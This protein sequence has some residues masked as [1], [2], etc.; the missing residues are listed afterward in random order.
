MTQESKY[1]WAAAIAAIVST[2]S[3]DFRELANIAQLDP[4]AGDLSDVDFSGLDLSGQNLGGWDLSKAKFVNARLTETELRSALVDPEEIIEAVDWEEANLDDSVRM[5]AKMAAK[6]KLSR[7]SRRVQ[8]LQ[9][10]V[11]TANCLKNQEIEYLGDLVKRSEAEL[12]RTQDFGRKSLNEVKEVLAEL[13]LHLGME[14]T[15]W[16]AKET[17]RRI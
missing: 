7:L 10:S 6:A 13:G 4:V 3:T 17:G 2:G 5:A 1:D 11:R 16:P 14:V 9:W 8:D 15:N 12:L